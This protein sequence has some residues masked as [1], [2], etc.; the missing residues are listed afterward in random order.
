MVY[1][2][3][4]WRR[5]VPRLPGKPDDLLDGFPVDEIRGLTG[6]LASRLA[7]RVVSRT[8]PAR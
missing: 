2:F 3:G 8:A 6:Q 5:R 7:A 4:Y 1:P